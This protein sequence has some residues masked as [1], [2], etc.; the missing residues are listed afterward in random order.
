MNSVLSW[1][2]LANEN[3]I[4]TKS[5]RNI[6]PE[7]V[8]EINEP[9]LSSMIQGLHCYKMLFNVSIIRDLALSITTDF[10]WNKVFFLINLLSY[11]FPLTYLLA[12]SFTAGIANQNGLGLRFSVSRSSHISINNSVCFNIKSRDI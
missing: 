12:C 7:E 4:F 2:D 9:F 5:F 10:F 1:K 3:L 8:I 6:L 11:S